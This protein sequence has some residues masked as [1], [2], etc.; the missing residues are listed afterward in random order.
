MNIRNYQILRWALPL[1]LLVVALW[2]FSHKTHET[3]DQTTNGQHVWQDPSMPQGSEAL[4]SSARK[5]QEPN[6]FESIWQI[7]Q[8][9]EGDANGL[10]QAFAAA[11]RGRNELP[12]GRRW[13]IGNVPDW[14][15]L[16][17]G[18]RLNVSLPELG[19]F[20]ATIA[21]SRKD[22]GYSDRHLVVVLFDGQRGVLN[23]ADDRQ[24]GGIKG[25][26]ILASGDRAWSFDSKEGQE[27]WLR[28]HLRGDLICDMQSPAAAM[29]ENPLPGDPAPPPDTPPS[30]PPILN[31]RPEATA[32]MFM[33]FDGEPPTIYPNWILQLGVLP[34]EV[35]HSGL[36]QSAMEFVWRR[37]AEDYIQFNVNV[38]TDATRYAAAPVGR[39]MRVLIGSTLPAGIEGGG[40]AWMNSFRAE[41]PFT[42]D[43][44][45]WVVVDRN[46][47]GSIAP[48]N[49]TMIA[50]AASHEFGHTLGLWH[51]GY[52]SAQP[53]DAST[54]NYYPGHGTPPDDWSPIMGTYYRAGTSESR[55]MVQWARNSYTG[56][57]NAQDDIGVIA[58]VANGFGMATDESTGTQDADTLELVGAEWIGATGIIQNASDQDWWRFTVAYPG[59]ATV[60]VAPAESGVSLPNLD[61]GFFI[62]DSNGNNL[63]GDIA[64]ENNL[65]AIDTRNLLPGTYYVVV[66]G[67]GR[68]SF[69]NN[70]GY[71][72]YG[73]T[74]RY[75]VT[76]VPPPENEGPLLTITS[77]VNNSIL[78]G[79]IQFQGTSSDTSGLNRLELK[80]QRASDGAY[81]NGVFWTFFPAN[82]LLSYTFQGNTNNWTC[83]ATMPQSGQLGGLTPG[84]YLFQAKAIDSLGNDSYSSSTLIVDGTGPSVAI[85]S[86]ASGSLLGTPGLNFFGTV[87]ENGT[88]QYVVGYIRRD[89]D[90]FYWN[91]SAWQAGTSGAHLSCNLVQRPSSTTYDWTC[92]APL[93][94]LGSSLTPGSYSFIA[95]AVDGAGLIQQRDAVVNVDSTGPVTTITAPAHQSII[96]TSAL[97]FHGS[98]TDNGGVWRV[99]CFIRRH[100]DNLYW[101]GSAWILDPGAANLSTSYNSSS[102]TWTCSSPLPV[103]GGTL[104]NGG[105]NFIAIGFDHAGNSHQVDSVV[106]VDFHQTYVWNGSAGGAWEN[107][108]SWTPNG[109]PGPDDYVLLNNGGT[110][111]NNA[112]RSVY[113]FRVTNGTMTSSA[114]NS[115]NF[116][117][118]STWSGGAIGG[119]WNNAATSTIV[120]N[121]TTVSSAPAGTVFNNYGLLRNDAGS[122]TL[123]IAIQQQENGRIQNNGSLL[124]LSGGGTHYPGSV[125]DAA[126]G[127]IYLHG[128]IHTFEG[129][130]FSGNNWTFCTGGTMLVQG[131]VGA[132][133]GA[134][135]GSFGISGGTVTGTGMVSAQ[136]GHFSTGTLSGSVVLRFTSSFTKPTNTVFNMNGGTLQID[137]IFESPG[138]A[139][140]NLDS[141]STAGAGTIHNKG[142]WRCSNAFTYSNSS[143]G[144]IFRNEGLFESLA[145]V[146][147]IAAAFHS[148][149]GSTFRSKSGYVRL[150]GGG[151]HD[152]GATFDTD[153]GD[154]YLSAGTH[155]FLGGSFTG[156]NHVYVT[157]GTMSVEGNVGASTGAATGGFAIAAG[158][159]TGNSL[160][161]VARGSLRDGTISGTVTIRLTGESTKLTN[162]NLEMNGG[163]IRN[164]GTMTA[165]LGGNF[166]LD[167]VAL[168]GAGTIVNT[169][170]WRTND[171]FTYSN[172]SSGGVFRNEGLFESMAGVSMI[173]GSFLSE[174]GSIFRVKSGY[175][176]LGGG[177]VHQPGST[178]D[179]DGG[180]IYLSAGTHQ[181]L[182]GTFMGSRYVYATGATVT[183]NG[184]VGASSG[185][186][187]GGFGIFAGTVNGTATLSAERGYFDA[188]AVGGTVT[189]RLTGASTKSS[190]SVLNMNGGTIR[191]EGTMSQPASAD[192]NLDSS[193]TAGAGTLVNIGTWN[194][195]GGSN[196]SNGS[197]AGSIENFGLWHCS[198]GNSN[199]YGYFTHHPDSTLRLTG[200][201][202]ILLGG[203]NIKAGATID[204]N[205]GHLYLNGGTHTLEGGTITGSHTVYSGGGTSVVTGNVGASSGPATG[206]FGI[207]SSGLVTGTGMLSVDHGYLAA[208]SMAGTVTLRFT[209]N[210]QKISS[211]VLNMNGGTIRNEGTMTQP[212]SA[213]INLDSDSTTGFG[214]I[215]NTGIWNQTGGS[216][217]SNGSDAGVI[218]NYGLWQ[219]SAGNS[220]TYAYFTHHPDSTFRCTA[221]QVIF[222][223]GGRLKAG[224]TIDAD[225]GAIYLSTG[226]HT[227]E[228]GTITGSSSVYTSAGTTTV[229]G[230]VGNTSGSA[231]GGYGVSGGTLNGSAMLS[232]ARGYFSNGTMGGTVTLRL[233]GAST[234]ASSTVLNMN[235]GIIRNEGTMTQ[236]ASADFNLDSSSSAGAGRIINVG[237]WNQTGGSNISNGSNGGT[238]D[239]HNLWHVSA[240]NSNHYAYF[241]HHGDSVFRCTTGQAIFLGGSRIKAGATL[242]ANGGYLYFSTGTHT[243]EGGTITGNTF[244]YTSAGITSVT[245]EVGPITGAA[246]GGYGIIGGVLNGSG[247]LSAERGYLANGTISGTVTLRLTGASTK[248][249]STVLDMNGGTIHN[250][251]AMTVGA[252]SDF[253]L[254][255][256]SGGGAGTIINTGTWTNTGGCNFTNASLGGSMQN[257]GTFEV[258]SGTT[259]I[260]APF[261]NSG[262]TRVTSGSLFLRASSVHTG[263]LVSN[264]NLTFIGSGHSFSG[265]NAYLGGSGSVSGNATLTN[266][267]RIAPGNSP[268]ALSL[269]G[270][271]QFLAS[272]EAP[273]ILMELASATQFDQIVLGNGASLALG[274]GVTDLLLDLQF[275]PDP[276]QTF[277]IISASTSTGTFSGRFRNAA[278]TGTLISAIY[279]GYPYQFRVNYDASNKFIDLVY[280][281]GYQLWTAQYNLTGNDALFNAGPDGD[282]VPN[283]IEFITGRDPRPGFPDPANP[284][285]NIPLLDETHLRFVHRR[286]AAARYLP[287][288][289]QYNTDLSPAWNLAT[290]GV[291]GVT[292]TTE[293]DFY[294][295]G[296]DKVETRIPRSLAS[297]GRLF[298]RMRAEE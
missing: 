206:G 253:S 14:R 214:T 146:S 182:G 96:T 250:E 149:P 141:V 272:T 24:M 179:A 278:T 33:D 80:L 122:T 224:A 26:V 120:L 189:I 266:A 211:T 116:T 183:V 191:N 202:I 244:V 7:S 261:T 260:Y 283:G 91:G 276:G 139:D 72:N 134:A 200:G 68:G 205:G 213:D 165:A 75:V 184:N 264:G 152:P 124:Y 231:T 117:N 180:D 99:V 119:V 111:T 147:M 254:D 167:S 252:S 227:L 127:A 239:N 199:T 221:G 242:D 161:S 296:I 109:I 145:G 225:G 77:P 150:G 170:T 234:K 256:S 265:P 286:V 268:G 101:N 46:I 107:A 67:T 17:E 20:P 63:T 123:P 4:S 132:T 76:V 251:G 97:P 236:P 237:T 277:R 22:R 113:G 166:N 42:S 34:F 282:G 255:S 105:Y 62:A 160:L 258:A 185:A 28:E 6:G 172:G 173:A 287:V 288:V 271:M 12:E 216:N 98:I 192:L 83:T 21:W 1:V 58:S 219:V 52:S 54:G 143:G 110:V 142:I 41:F 220:N 50:N 162:T 273:A 11:A 43:V 232:V 249:A 223:G 137:G 157:G 48:A 248:V 235:G 115:L 238:I 106:T 129:G 175:V 176:R 154:I 13:K 87:T 35:P 37:V 178:F 94:S 32:T 188:G 16:R 69:S 291:N 89:S 159:V 25:H 267:A 208:G 81:W 3:P 198:A 212:A 269:F 294:G 38:T 222:L 108:G 10:R 138:A 60:E 293:T 193:S 61:C 84:E 262:L 169:G 217:L 246:R 131:N 44:P 112:I 74:G 9:A 8:T 85:L 31:S 204:A 245:G 285:E 274:T 104:P 78:N 194:Q 64:P 155:Q 158:T 73:S 130:S 228:G 229:Q 136:R 281:S 135:T 65:A 90:G 114:G 71:D 95:I 144:G 88:L 92:N 151:I 19:T 263:G 86:P 128:G 125:L 2:I 197:G 164:E 53:S 257:S 298:L 18:D 207:Y 195:T 49:L 140:F 275:R 243:L 79:S 210:S 190:S 121:N 56:A 174:A 126:S 209:G 270:T 218:D 203:G 280:Q 51:D 40:V 295:S 70:T 118:D 59:T 284:G 240:G 297:E 93:P 168:G 57:N 82:T 289:V 181:L 100:A 259:Q 177:G 5:A 45:C 15:N 27:F 233:T 186:A 102:G 30:P 163:T 226:T 290:H 187:S 103:P 247:L 171:A 230:D 196:I 201:Q 153:G 279:Q 133:T 39:R 47:G 156:T 292:I 23:L 148:E 36:S 66:K 55:T 241:T 29:R 215:V